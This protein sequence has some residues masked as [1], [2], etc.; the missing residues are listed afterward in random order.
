MR[1]DNGVCFRFF[2]NKYYFIW[3]NFS[4][5]LGFS[6]RLPVSLA[7]SCRGSDRHEFWGLISGQVVHGKFAPRCNDI[8]NPTLRL[9]HNWVAITLFPRDGPRPVR[10]DELMILYAMVNK[11]RISPA[12][13]MV[14]QW[15]TNF[16]MTGPIEYTSLVTRIASNMGILDGNP[17]LSLRSPV[18]WSMRRN[19]FKATYSRKARMTPWFSFL[20]VMQMKS[21]CQTRGIICITVVH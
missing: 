15:L 1:M 9:V 3:K 14:K 11:I 16:R 13:A 10:N 8:Q 20:S 7:K 6:G 4:H 18:L 12:Q 19:W 17:F 2:G 5:L 21:R